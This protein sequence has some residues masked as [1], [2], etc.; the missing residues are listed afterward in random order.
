MLRR[1][2]PLAVALTLAGCAQLGAPTRN[3][4][5]LTA[6]YGCI[7][8]AFTGLSPETAAKMTPE[9]FWRIDEAARFATQGTV[10]CIG[11][12]GYEACPKDL[13]FTYDEYTKF[14]QDRLAAQRAAAQEQKAAEPA[15]SPAQPQ[16]PVK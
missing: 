12:H 4:Y 16:A 6:T 9:E 7:G 5:Q 8:D 14:R 15:Q 3:G 10:C 1:A 11:P 13:G 2:L